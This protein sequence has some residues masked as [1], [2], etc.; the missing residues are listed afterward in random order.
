MSK[1]RE[2]LDALVKVHGMRE[3]D[4]WKLFYREIDV[5]CSECDGSKIVEI[6]NDEW[7]DYSCAMCGGECEKRTIPTDWDD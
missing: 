6:S 3:D 2:L 1:E 7:P 4:V 5:Y